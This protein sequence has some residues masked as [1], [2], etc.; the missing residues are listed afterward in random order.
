MPLTRLEVDAL[1]AQLA[2]ADGALDTRNS[3]ERAEWAEKRQRL[4]LDEA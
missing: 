3:R 2:G 1:K 4:G